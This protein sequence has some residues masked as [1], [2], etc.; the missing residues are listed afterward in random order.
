[1]TKSFLFFTFFLSSFEFNGSDEFPSND[2]EIESFEVELN[3]IFI[4]NEKESSDENKGL[5]S[6]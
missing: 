6:D 5:L 4:S 2:K 1:M 3:K